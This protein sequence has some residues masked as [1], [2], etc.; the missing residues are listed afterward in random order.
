MK[1]FDSLPP[2]LHVSGKT[3]PPKSFTC[4]SDIYTV[5][6]NTQ[7]FIKISALHSYT[8]IWG[9]DT[10]IFAPSRRLEGGST[11]GNGTLKKVHEG[12]SCHSPEVFNSALGRICLK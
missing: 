4:G 8:K 3:E 12:H 1:S 10:L 5:T 7:V 9:E 11:V 6:A 2:L